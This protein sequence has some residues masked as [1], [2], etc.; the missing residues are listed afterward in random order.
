MHILLITSSRSQTYKVSH[1]ILY[2]TESPEAER[3]WDRPSNT[4]SE[5]P[6]EWLSFECFSSTSYTMTAKAVT[7]D[8]GS[9]EWS[10]TRKNGI[11]LA[12]LKQ[13]WY[14]RTPS[15]TSPK[16][17]PAS[18]IG[19]ELSRLWGEGKICY[20]LD[21]G[22]LYCKERNQQFG[23]SNFR[24]IVKLDRGSTSWFIYDKER[25][26]FKPVSGLIHNEDFAILKVEDLENQMFEAPPSKAWE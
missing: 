12:S 9:S 18:G 17:D 5:E 13:T 20:L 3:S 19:A 25:N 22:T 1:N 10:L 15:F 24:R 7:N 6:G 14:W 2:V 23:V 8:N 16:M 4:V 26:N 21:F 11:I